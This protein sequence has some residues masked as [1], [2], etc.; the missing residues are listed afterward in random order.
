MSGK[1]KQIVVKSI[2]ALFALWLAFTIPFP[3]MGIEGMEVSASFNAALLATKDPDKIIKNED[4]EVAYVFLMEHIN[5][6]E[7]LYDI[8]PEAHAKMDAVFH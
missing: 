8:S 1:A 4:R 7:A 6:L 5:S 2:L 3:G